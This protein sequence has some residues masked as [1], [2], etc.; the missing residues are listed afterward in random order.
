MQWFLG[1]AAEG[2]HGKTGQDATSASTPGDETS[3]T[4]GIDKAKKP[5]CRRSGGFFGGTPPQA[6]RFEAINASR[7]AS[8]DVPCGSRPSYVRLHERHA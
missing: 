1:H 4:K 6:G 7:I 2:T 5:P 3:K 8:C